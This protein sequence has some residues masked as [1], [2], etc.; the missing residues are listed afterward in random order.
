MTPNL[1]TFRPA[2]P[3]DADA[4]T[5]FGE[6]MFRETFGPYHPAEAMDEYC[7]ATYAVERVRGELADPERHTV[8][9]LHRDQIVGYV[10]LHVAPAPECVSGPDPLELLRFYVDTA[11]HGRGVAPAL[12]A[13]VVAEA[14]R[15]GGRTLF[16]LVWEYNLRAIAFYQKHGFRAVGSQPFPLG[17][18]RPND[19]VMVRDLMRVAERESRA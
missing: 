1:I 5:V 14:E 7:R 9:A 4:L 2:T 19:Y 13:R 18:E 17:G 8:V 12:M 11:W 15:R 16:L 6:R 10:Q 3:D